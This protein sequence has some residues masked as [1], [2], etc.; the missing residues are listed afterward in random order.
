ML[1]FNRATQGILRHFNYTNG[2]ESPHDLQRFE[3]AQVLLLLL[4]MLLVFTQVLDSDNV[5]SIG[6]C[7]SST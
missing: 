6:T 1:S 5:K 3:P 4:K 2:A 7:T